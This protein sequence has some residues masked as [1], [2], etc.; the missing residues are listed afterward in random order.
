MRFNVKPVC[1]SFGLHRG[2]RYYTVKEV[3]RDVLGGKSEKFVR[4]LID[5]KQIRY[6]DISSAKAK[7]REVLIPE[8]AID[9]FF[10][11]RTTRSQAEIPP[12]ALS[13]SKKTRRPASQ[14]GFMAT[15]NSHLKR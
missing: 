12:P 11:E 1:A 3:A 10:A 14:Q 6:V 8:D 2:R 9:E 13:A 5:G 15:I 7:R 4:N